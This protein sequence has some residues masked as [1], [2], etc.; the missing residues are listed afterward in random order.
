MKL[1]GYYNEVIFNGLGKFM[2]GHL[3]NSLMTCP[4]LN[5]NCY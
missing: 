2:E 3:F 1:A 4:C 5:I